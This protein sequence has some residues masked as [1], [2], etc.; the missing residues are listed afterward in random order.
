VGTLKKNII[1]LAIIAAAI[2]LFLITRDPSDPKEFV[3]EKNITDYS[4]AF[5]YYKIIR[6]PT[7]IEIIQPQE[8]V[9]LGI[10]TDPWNL[11]FGSIPGNGSYVKRYVSVTNLNEKYNKIR[12]KPYGNITSLLNFSKNDFTM[13]ENESTVVEVTL[14]TNN[15]EIGN[16]SGEIDAIIKVPK[17]DFLSVLT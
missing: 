4:N 14:N 12:L 7:N 3:K 10:A 13:N 8:N 6:Y 2:F 9:N 17:Y 16:Y 1:I 11:N 5:F 15:A